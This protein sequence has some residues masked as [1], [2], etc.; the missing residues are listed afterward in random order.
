MPSLVV[1]RIA[2]VVQSVYD[3]P[4]PDSRKHPNNLLPTEILPGGAGEYTAHVN[5]LKPRTKLDEKT[6]RLPVN[7]R[8]TA[9][10]SPR[11]GI[12]VSPIYLTYEEAGILHPRLCACALDPVNCMDCKLR[13]R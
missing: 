2:A 12:A 9:T 8:C 10:S 5:Q 11:M 13:R 6:E 4:V 3:R 7:D 1:M